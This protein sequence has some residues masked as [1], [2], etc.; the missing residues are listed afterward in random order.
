MDYFT[1]KHPIQ[2][3]KNTLRHQNCYMQQPLSGQVSH[4]Y[5]PTATLV[6]TISNYYLLTVRKQLIS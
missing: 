4:Y 2:N 5:L 6:R 1:H 3:C